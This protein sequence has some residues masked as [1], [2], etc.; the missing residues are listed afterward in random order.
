VFTGEGA[1][2]IDVYGT[3]ILAAHAY[4]TSR[5]SGQTLTNIV[6]PPGS[7]GSTDPLNQRQTTGWKGTFTAK[8]L[9]NNFLTR[10]ETAVAA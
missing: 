2:G 1:A 8:I 3:V 5:I 10:I 9:N 4:G 6:K 7:G